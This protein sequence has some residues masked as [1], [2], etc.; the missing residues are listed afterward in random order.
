M[1]FLRR[2]RACVRFRSDGTRTG[3]EKSGYD[4]EPIRIGVTIQGR[5]GGDDRLM[6]TSTLFQW[7]LLLLC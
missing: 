2:I 3:S 4:A 7:R 6:P 5:W 1:P